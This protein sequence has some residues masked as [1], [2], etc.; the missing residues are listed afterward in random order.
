VKLSCSN[1]TMLVHTGFL[2]VFV[3]LGVGLTGDAQDG[4]EWDVEQVK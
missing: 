3:K 2:H 4:F 1:M